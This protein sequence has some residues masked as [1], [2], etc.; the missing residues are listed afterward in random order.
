M[1]QK[2]NESDQN[3]ATNRTAFFAGSFNPFTLGHLD[4]ARRALQVVDRLVIGVGFN[5]AKS[6]CHDVGARVE[7]IRSIFAGEQRVEVM[8]YEGL[9]VKVARRVGAGILLR[10]VRSNADFE[11]ERN[12]ADVNREIAGMETIILIADPRYSFIS[13]SMVRE[14]RDNG[15]DVA[16]FLPEVPDN[17]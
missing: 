6:S 1:T 9:T 8:A 3:T 16:R 7:N 2:Y 15:Y 10:G 4:I 11:Y 5:C 13:S 14:L 17:Q 12:L